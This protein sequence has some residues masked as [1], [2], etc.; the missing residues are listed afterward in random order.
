MN[1]QKIRINSKYFSDFYPGEL[2][3]LL[4]KIQNRFEI[5]CENIDN[6]PAGDSGLKCVREKFHTD[7]K[8]K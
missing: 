6:S 7:M 8:L 4:D 3:Q 5:D 2:T 1:S